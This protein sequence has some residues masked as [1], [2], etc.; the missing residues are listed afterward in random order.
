MSAASK[1]VGQAVAVVAAIAETIREVGEIPSGQLYASLM[2]SGCTFP[3]YESI[4][5]VL[6]RAGL[7]SVESHVV[8]W[9]GP[10]IEKVTP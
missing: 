10:K 4:L 6:K 5:G 1:Q 7:V 9:V 2:P 3:Q 8:R